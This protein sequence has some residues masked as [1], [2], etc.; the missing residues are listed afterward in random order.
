MIFLQTDTMTADLFSQFDLLTHQEPANCSGF[1]FISEYLNIWFVGHRP[2][3]ARE[4][5]PYP[6]KMCEINQVFEHITLYVI[7]S[8]LHVYGFS[9][10]MIHA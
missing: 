3:S 5:K 8:L 7:V 4:C 1:E 2:S 10:P 9:D 6:L